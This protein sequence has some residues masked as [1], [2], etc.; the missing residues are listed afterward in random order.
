MGFLIGVLAWIF[1]V[2]VPAVGLI[3]TIYWVFETAS[4]ILRAMLGLFGYVFVVLPLY[5]SVVSAVFAH[6][7]VY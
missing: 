3:L 4:T 2:I 1:V 6:F 7:G 5:F